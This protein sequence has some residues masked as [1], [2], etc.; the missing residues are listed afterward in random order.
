MYPCAVDNTF[1]HTVYIVRIILII[2][3]MSCFTG[4]SPC[5]TTFEL[6]ICFVISEMIYY[7]LCVVR[8]FSMTYTALCSARHCECCVGSVY[9]IAHKY[10]RHKSITPSSSSPS[11]I[12]G[13]VFFVKVAAVR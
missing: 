8:V 10:L 12:S 9:T 7:M 11:D 4:M 6:F 1:D 3:C 2:C 13:S 5:N